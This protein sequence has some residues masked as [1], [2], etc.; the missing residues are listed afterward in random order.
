MYSFVQNFNKYSAYNFNQISSI[1]SK[2]HTLNRFY[3]DVKKLNDVKTENKNTKQKETNVLKIHHC[4]MI[5]CL[6]CI[7]RNMIRLL[8]VKMKIGG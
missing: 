2:F 3:K 7:K 6:I 5:G 1:V 4:F 8:K